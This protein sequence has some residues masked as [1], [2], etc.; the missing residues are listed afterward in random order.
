MSRALPLSLSKNLS[1]SWTASFAKASAKAWRGQLLPSIG[2][3]ATE[4]TSSRDNFS[5]SSGDLVG[6]VSVGVSQTLF[7]GGREKARWDE[8][9]VAHSEARHSLNSTMVKVAGEVRTAHK[10]LEAAQS[11]LRLHRDNLGLVRQYRDLVE[12]GYVAGQLELTH[13]NQAQ[14]DLTLAEAQLAL[15]RAGL[16]QAWNDLNSATAQSIEALPEED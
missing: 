3:S 12:E 8:A 11:Q 7:S 9:K 4:T 2:L 15:A 14:R 1:A 10:A 5:T 13:L 16:R 6:A